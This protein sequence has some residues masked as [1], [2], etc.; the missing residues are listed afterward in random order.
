MRA[1]RDSKFEWDDPWT[2]SYNTWPI[3]APTILPPDAVVERIVSG[4]WGGHI[5]EVGGSEAL[6]EVKKELA[7]LQTPQTHFLC[8][9]WP[10]P[11]STSCSG[12]GGS[13]WTIPDSC[14]MDCHGLSLIAWDTAVTFSKVLTELDLSDL[15]AS[16]RDFPARIFALSPFTVGKETPNFSETRLSVMPD[17]AAA[18]RH[19]TT[20]WHFAYLSITYPEWTASRCPP[21]C[22]RVSKGHVTPEAIRC[23]ATNRREPRQAYCERARTFCAPCTQVMKDFKTL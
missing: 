6:H 20:I 15:G 3:R 5:S 12:P 11:T 1:L 16:S 18:R 13:G 19:P 17:S 2:S 14:L 7:S 22:C 10:G 4:D 8:E 23:L 9:T 21:L